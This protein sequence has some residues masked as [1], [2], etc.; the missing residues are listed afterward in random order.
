VNEKGEFQVKC[1]NLREYKSNCV[2]NEV[3]NFVIILLKTIE[4]ERKM[5]K[6]EGKVIQNWKNKLIFGFRKINFGQKVIFCLNLFKI[7]S[8]IINVALSEKE[9]E[10]IF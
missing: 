1:V 8:I 3:L 5:I 9:C 2:K 4:N 7:Y 10:F 6:S